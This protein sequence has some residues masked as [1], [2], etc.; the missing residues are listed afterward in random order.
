M[1]NGKKPRGRPTLAAQS[2]D[3]AIARHLAGQSPK[4]PR[5]EFEREVMRRSGGRPANPAALTHVAA[6]CAAYLVQA[7]GLSPTRAAERA[8]S[9]H[10]VDAANVRRYARK[11]IKGPQVVVRYRGRSGGAE[12]M[13]WVA[14]SAQLVQ[15]RTVPLVADADEVEAAFRQAESGSETLS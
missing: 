14:L 1:T 6:E 4:R 13:P 2:L 12:A 9:M 3:E 11:I 8:S 7:L 5:N 15:P 10:G